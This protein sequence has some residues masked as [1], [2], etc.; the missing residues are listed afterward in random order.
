MSSEIVPGVHRDISF[1]DYAALDAINSGVVRWGHKA[2]PLHMDAARRGL[3]ES[4]DT[5]DRKFGRAVHC[6]LLEPERYRK[7]F[8]IA[9]TCVGQKRDGTVCGNRAKYLDGGR[10][11]CGTHAHDDAQQPTDYIDVDE[12]ARNERLA[13]RLH[14]HPVNTLL[15]RPG[16]SEVVIVWERKGRLLK[17]RLDRLDEPMDFILD[18]KK[19]QVGKATDRQCQS[20]I[21]SHG[22][23]IQAAL[24]CDA[25]K[26]QHPLGRRPDFAWVFIDDNEPYGVNVILA[27]DETLEIGL[28]EADEAL[29][30]YGECERS[31]V[32]PDY[33]RNPSRILSGGLPEFYRKEWHKRRSA[34]EGTGR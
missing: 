21:L 10:W 25:V 11:Y 28:D 7:E 18:V 34:I 15:R 19:C 8:L 16:W 23:H 6:R 5:K 14:A 2:T 22:Y 27:D 33:I 20:A 31:G 29:K 13:E 9:T 12:A 30:H 1:A 32:F 3:I 24:Y 4:D 17:C 26:S